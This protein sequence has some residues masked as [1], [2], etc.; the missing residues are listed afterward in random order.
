MERSLV[1][2]GETTLMVSIPAAWARRHGLEKGDSIEMLDEGES[3][4]MLKRGNKR[5]PLR[6]EVFFESP[7]IDEIRAILCKFYREGADEVIV[8][9]D[10]EDIFQLV[11]NAVASIF[12]YEI[13]DS[14][15]CQCTIKN[16]IKEFDFDK[17]MVFKK[18]VAITDSMFDQAKEIISGK[19]ECDLERVQ[20]LRSE[21][22][23]F[24]DA[25]FVMLKKETLER[26]FA[27]EFILHIYEQNITYLTWLIKCFADSKMKQVSPQFLALYDRV[28]KYFIDSLVMMKKKDTKYLHF[29]IDGRR[30]L[31]KE[32]ED[33]SFRGRNE[34]KLALY[35]AMLIQNIHNPK[36]VLIS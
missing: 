24:R 25:S 32:C 30:K 14:Q 27:D 21:G 22:W 2:H 28:Q 36:P 19:K 33:I 31:L 4:V 9:Y 8:K 1:K 7:D 6:R 20:L 13:T 5:Q 18:I 3:L 11:H 17:D 16:L 34:A 26:S 12:G 10:N 23:K 29:I 35:L 15:K